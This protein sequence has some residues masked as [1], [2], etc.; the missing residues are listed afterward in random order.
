[1]ALY[2]HCDRGP[3]GNLDQRR[4]E[5]QRQKALMIDRLSASGVKLPRRWGGE[6]MAARVPSE[7]VRG[8]EIQGQ[9]RAREAA[10]KRALRAELRRA[11]ELAGEAAAED[12]DEEGDDGG[13]PETLS[14]W[15]PSSRSN[16]RC[17]SCRWEEHRCNG[18]LGGLR[19]AVDLQDKPQEYVDPVKGLVA[20]WCRVK[21]DAKIRSGFEATS[22]AC[23][24]AK[25][26]QLIEI[27]E[28]RLNEKEIRRVRF[29]ANPMRPDQ[30][31]V[32]A[33]AADGTTMLERVDQETAEKAA[34]RKI[35]AE[36]THAERVERER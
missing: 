31:W 20:E 11:R 13:E 35:A 14:Y 22:A 25:A 18:C 6:S 29:D 8:E 12:D 21:V 28:T 3:Y 23:G 16:P 15:R 9:V 17:E 24:L 27:L 2:E 19:V 1:M 10:E 36:K 26:G 30:G 7:A 32:S 34:V 5:Q 33:S 4:E